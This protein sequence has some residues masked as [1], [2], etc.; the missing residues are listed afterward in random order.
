MAARKLEQIAYREEGH[1]KGFYIV[2]TKEDLPHS[3]ESFGNPTLHQITIDRED[4]IYDAVI[5][6]AR[7]RGLWNIV[8]AYSISKPLNSRDVIIAVQLYRI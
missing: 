4:I 6:S 8:N 1:R 2:K 5:D 3:P 7:S